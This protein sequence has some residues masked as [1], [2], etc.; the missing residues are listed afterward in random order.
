LT[1]LLFDDAGHRMIPTHATK[2][3]VRYR[4]YVSLPHLHGESKTASVGSVSRISATE[5]EDVIVKSLQQ[6]LIA[7]KEKS[8]SITGQVR[9]HKALQDS[10]ARI[11]VHEDHLAIR[12]KS[13][14]GEE[15]SDW[16]DDIYSQS[17]GESRH[18]GDP[19][20]SS[21]QMASPET[22]FVRLGSSVAR[23][24]SAPSPEVAAGLTRSCRAP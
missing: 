8:S 21:S 4:Y 7:Q 14:D 18:P 6:Y 22:K 24:S 2:A 15:T 13:A 19:G 12:L 10:I 23:A 11:D 9:D 16:A 17:R 5:I 20:R 3:A 1:G